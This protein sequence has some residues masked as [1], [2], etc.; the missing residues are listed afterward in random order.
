MILE[1]SNNRRKEI[2]NIVCSAL[3]HSKQAS[4]PVKIGAIIRSY[5]NIKLITY[6][7]Q[8]KKGK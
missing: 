7:S 2:K 6:S 4:V 3:L 8:V 5:E 1:I